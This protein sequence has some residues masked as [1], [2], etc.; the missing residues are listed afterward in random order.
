MLSAQY[1]RSSFLYLTLVVLLLI[2]GFF[3]FQLFN[4]DSEPEQKIAS[5]SAPVTTTAT[6][7]E[8]EQKAAVTEKVETKTVEPAPAPPLKAKDVPAVPAVKSEAATAKNVPPAPPE[9]AKQP[10]SLPATKTT[11][12]PPAPAAKPQES[13][14]PVATKQ[15]VAVAKEPAPAGTAA[16]LSL[17]MNII[18]QREEAE[19]GYTEIL[20]SEGSVLRSHDN[21]QVHLETSRPAYVYILMYDS[22][23]KASQ[24]FPDPKANQ[25]GSVEGGSKLVVPAKDLWFWL[26]DST[27]TETIYVLAS[28]KPMSDIQG[29]LTKMESTDEAGQKRASQQIKERIAVMQRGVGG[30]MKGQSVT[31]TLS[32]GK[33]IQKV[34]DVV[35]GAGSVV[36]AVSFQHR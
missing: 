28:E 35:Q 20:V 23:G 6:P 5:A 34:T 17:R 3:A 10:D 19:G 30:I 36:R 32:D 29:L 4:R 11:D 27:G 31:Y 21:F 13:A 18:G 8:P 1:G 7:S 2:V 25:P 33:K 16:P 24:I 14:P 26:D 9:R 12:A 22:Q 15:E